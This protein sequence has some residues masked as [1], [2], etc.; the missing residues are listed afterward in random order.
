MDEN[1]A[2]TIPEWKDQAIGKNRI[3][4]RRDEYV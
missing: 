4:Q 1:V 3:Y 2:K